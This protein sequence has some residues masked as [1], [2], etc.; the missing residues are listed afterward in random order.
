MKLRSL[1]WASFRL[2]PE[3]LFQ[4]KENQTMP[5]NAVATVTA[6]LKLSEDLQEAFKGMTL[7]DAE[8]LL[9][10]ISKLL[11]LDLY[12][13][14]ASEVQ[15]TFYAGEFRLQ[16]FHE[17]G[18]IQGTNFEQTYNSYEKTEAIERNSQ[19]TKT[20]LY[21]IQARKKQLL[22]Q[23]LRNMARITGQTETQA[24]TVISFEL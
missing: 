4:R 20:L 10:G 14:P 1:F 6:S 18:R 23:T 9:N 17:A 8:L 12:S 16:F 5:C 13:F 11:Q 21:L 19:F 22:A 2:Q 24:G 3:I 7:K 15:Q